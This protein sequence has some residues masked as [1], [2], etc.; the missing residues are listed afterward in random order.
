M[1]KRFTHVL[2]W[3]ISLINPPPLNSMTRWQ[4]TARIV[5]FT[6]TMVVTCI[7]LSMVA[8]AAIFTLQHEKR[9][10]KGLP[11]LAEDLG[12]IL[13]SMIV[14]TLCVLLLLRI[15]Q[16]DQKLIPPS[17]DPKPPESDSP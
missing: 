2:T 12:I 9:L 3:L 13:L 17:E 10:H 5:L 4:K 7:L 1:L 15:K 8:A 14:N 6:A 16:A 11:E